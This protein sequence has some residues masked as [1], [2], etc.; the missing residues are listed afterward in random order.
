MQLQET[1][2][3]VASGVLGIANTLGEI[4]KESL[5]PNQSNGNINCGD[6]I[7]ASGN[8]DFHFQSMT[9]KEEYARIIDNYFSMFGY[10]VNE[11]K[12][13]NLTGRRNWNYVKTIDINIEATIPQADLEEIKNEFNSGI[14]IWHN[15]STFLDYSQNN[16]II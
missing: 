8:N 16:D 1:L 3:G 7:T 9:I 12:I 15:T 4:Y 13:P 11:T 5:I 14:T 10:K 6:V 2:F